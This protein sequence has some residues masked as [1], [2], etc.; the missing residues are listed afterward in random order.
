MLSQSRQGGF[1]PWRK[2]HWWASIRSA[3]FSAS[4]YC[5]RSRCSSEA[6]PSMQ[7]LQLDDVVDSVS[8]YHPI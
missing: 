8:Q 6:V 5:R 7:V 1:H 3:N 2:A 4:S